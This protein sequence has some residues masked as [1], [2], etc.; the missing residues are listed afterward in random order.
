MCGPLWLGQV[1]I[2]VSVHHQFFHLGP[3]AYG[4]DNVLYGQ[5]VIGG[6]ITPQDI[7]PLPSRQQ[8]KADDVRFMEAERLQG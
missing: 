3:S 1:R 6:N 8:L 4:R 7:P 5:G 2:E